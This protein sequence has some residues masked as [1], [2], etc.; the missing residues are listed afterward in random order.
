M[1]NR[2]TATRAENA[3]QVLNKT[4]IN[5]TGTARDLFPYRGEPETSGSLSVSIFGALGIPLTPERM[6][7]TL[8][9]N[10][11]VTRILR[12]GDRPSGWNTYSAGPVDERAQHEAMKFVGTLG[13]TVPRP[14]I[15]PLANRGIAFK[16][17]TG[18]R[19]IDVR[20]FPDGRGDYCVVRRRDE[21]LVAEGVIHSAETL[22]RIVEEH[23]LGHLPP[24]TV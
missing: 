20:F 7:L 18:D 8:N 16:W 14:N 23:V 12:L 4:S 5:D 3:A 17:L 22:K 9:I 2:V 10:P 24:L 6:R 1:R 21:Q 15:A 13:A 19:E 11:L